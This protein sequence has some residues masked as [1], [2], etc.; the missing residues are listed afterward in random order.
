[1]VDVIIGM[2]DSCTG[3]EGIT[4]IEMAHCLTFRIVC[5][6]TSSGVYFRGRQRKDSNCHPVVLYNL[7]REDIL[8]IVG[9]FVNK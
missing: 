9:K 2:E 3:W 7:T 6:R 8:E 1:M 4:M 5:L